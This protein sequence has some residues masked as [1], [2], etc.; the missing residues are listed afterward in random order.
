MENFNKSF[1]LK[2]IDLRSDTVTLP[3]D[4]MR[5]AMKNAEV[6]DDVYKED[7]TVNRLEELAAKKL[8]KEAALFVSSGTMGNLI[9]VLTHCQKGDEVILE[10]ERKLYTNQKFK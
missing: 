8:G 2:K 4:E 3:T 10:A 6:G 5:E 1:N 7:P 9:A